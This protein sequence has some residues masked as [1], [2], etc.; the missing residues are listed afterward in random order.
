MGL[1]YAWGRGISADR[2]ASI[3]WLKRSGQQGFGPGILAL[4][5]ALSGPGALIDE[6]EKVGEPTRMDE[7]SD[8]VMA[9]FW[10]EAASHSIT[11]YVKEEALFRLDELIKRMSP[12]DLRRA[13][14]LV[15]NY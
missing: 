11:P 13:K 10:L 15:K 12:E 4:G 3:E 2:G 8:L 5:M 9:Y 7:Y 6:A 1:A 14:N